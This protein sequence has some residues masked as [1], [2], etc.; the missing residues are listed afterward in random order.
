MNSSISST[1]GSGSTD[2]KTWAFPGSSTS[3]AS[4]IREAIQ[5]PSS[6][7]TSWSSTRYR[8]NVGAE[9]KGNTARVSTSEFMRRSWAAALGLAE[10]RK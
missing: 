2:Q 8:H 7:A 6:I 4:G 5:R 1:N 10:R 9:I 3:L